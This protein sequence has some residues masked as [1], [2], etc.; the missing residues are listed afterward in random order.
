MNFRTTFLIQLW[1][2]CGLT[3]RPLSCCSLLD[4]NCSIVSLF[5]FCLYWSSNI[6]NY[7]TEIFLWNT[8]CKHFF[9]FKLNIMANKFHYFLFMLILQLQFQK[10]LVFWASSAPSTCGVF[11]ILKRWIIRFCCEPRP[12]N[13]SECRGKE[14]VSP[15]DAII[16]KVKL[17][18]LDIV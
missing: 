4:P 9:V 16:E 5:F 13:F 7:L 18:W 2:V 14:N 8:L 12:N 11:L 1:T 15:C 3:L 17:N 6:P 10:K